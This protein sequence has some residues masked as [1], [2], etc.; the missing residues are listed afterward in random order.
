MILQRIKDKKHIHTVPV[1]I[2]KP[3]EDEHKEHIATRF[4]RA[5]DRTMR[6]IAS[7]LGPSQVNYIGM[8]GKSKVP[9]GIA[10]ANEQQ[11]ILM[12]MDYKVR[13]SDHSFAI[14]GKHKLNPSVIS[15][16]DVTPNKFGS[17]AAVS[18]KGETFLR[19]QSVKHDSVSCYDH[20][21]DLLEVFKTDSLKPRLWG[22]TGPKPVLFIRSDGGMDVNITTL[23]AVKVFINVFKELDLDLLAISMSAPGGSAHNA[24]ERRMAP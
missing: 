2:F 3:Q 11:A 7:Y 1:R 9:L 22:P 13:L 10:A 12:R 8:D 19:I 5:D 6:E 20:G 18:Y 24:V 15:L 21:L 14:R 4:C 16:H 17:A 23:P